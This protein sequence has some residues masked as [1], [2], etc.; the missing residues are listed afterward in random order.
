MEWST[1]LGPVIVAVVPLLVAAM[2]RWKA[3]TWTYPLIAAALGVAADTLSAITMNVSLGP[4]AGAVAGL[5]GVGLREV[6]DQ[7]K[8]LGG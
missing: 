2:K 3:Q 5:A 4:V 8:K 6:V 1:A 7:L